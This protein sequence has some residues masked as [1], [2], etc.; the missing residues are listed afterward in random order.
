[1]KLF[2]FLVSIQWEYPFHSF[3]T[4]IEI[5][6]SGMEPV[7]WIQKG[8]SHPRSLLCAFSQPQLLFLH[9]STW[10]TPSCLSRHGSCHSYLSFLPAPNIRMN[11]FN[12]CPSNTLF[13]PWFHS[14]INAS[15]Q[16]IFTE[17]PL[18]VWNW[19]F[20]GGWQ[21]PWCLSRC[22]VQFRVSLT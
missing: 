20:T 8:L 7:S 15:I 9:F 16:Q 22:S 3:Q 12:L 2:I 5:L 17:N 11:A 21:L 4:E 6:F 1:M 18:Y 10:V 19:G 14:V 13:T